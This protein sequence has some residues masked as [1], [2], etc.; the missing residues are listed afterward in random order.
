MLSITSR[1]WSD[2]LSTQCTFDQVFTFLTLNTSSYLCTYTQKFV[3]C[4]HWYLGVIVTTEKVTCVLS[5]LSSPCT[6]GPRRSPP[7]SLLLRASPSLSQQ[8]QGLA[9]RNPGRPLNEEAESRLR[10]QVW[11]E[12]NPTIRSL[13]RPIVQHLPKEGECWRLCSPPQVSPNF[14]SHE[15]QLLLP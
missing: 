12:A 5:C 4:A 10:L 15:F 2:I 1:K 8:G 3:E 13:V 7:P 6:L 9:R 14:C 11:M